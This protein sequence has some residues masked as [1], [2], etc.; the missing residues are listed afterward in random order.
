MTRGTAGYMWLHQDPVHVHTC[1]VGVLLSRALLLTLAGLAT[2]WGDGALTPGM[3]LC[4]RKSVGFPRVSSVFLPVDWALPGRANENWKMNRGHSELLGSSVHL[5]AM[6]S[7]EGCAWT[8]LG[9]DR[10]LQWPWAKVVAWGVTACGCGF[11]LEWWL[12]CLLFRCW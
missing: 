6:V 8:P 4:S 2:C 10:R 11:L 9:R 12:Y 7:V 1:I 5:M 3:L